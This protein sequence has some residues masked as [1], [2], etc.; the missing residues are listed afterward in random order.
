MA[1]VKRLFT[2]DYLFRGKYVPMVNDLTSEIDPS[3]GATIF[4]SAVELYLVSAIVGAHYQLTANPDNT[5][6]TKRIMTSQFTN[7]YNDLKFA[8]QLVMLNADRDSLS[9]VDRINNA[10]RYSEADPEYP[11]IVAMFERYMLGGLVF[12]HDRF[13]K[14]TNTHF[15]DYRISLDELLSEMS[16]QKPQE[17]SED[18]IDFGPAF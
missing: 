2:D 1:T 15:D 8:F 17:E 9:P 4:R 3:S 13:I 6:E 11:G 5:G 7:H 14:P 18:D 10:F 12:L 16:G